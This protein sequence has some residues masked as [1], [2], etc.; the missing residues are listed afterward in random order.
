MSYKEYFS[1]RIEELSAIVTNLTVIGS[2][3]GVATSLGNSEWAFRFE[4]TYSYNGTAYHVYQII[5]VSGSWP[6]QDGY[7]FTYTAPE[8]VYS[9]HLAEVTKMTEKVNF[10]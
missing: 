8:S 10:K 9:S 5:A 4:Y 6:M 3:D 7:V 1:S 2:T